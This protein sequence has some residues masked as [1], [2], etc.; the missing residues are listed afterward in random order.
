MQLC[1]HVAAENNVSAKQTRFVHPSISIAFRPRAY[2]KP[3][4][5]QLLLIDSV[6]VSERRVFI[7]FSGCVCGWPLSLQTDRSDLGTL[8]TKKELANQ[9]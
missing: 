8:E 1:R 3:N 6:H 2:I 4:V 5:N 9:P 7:T